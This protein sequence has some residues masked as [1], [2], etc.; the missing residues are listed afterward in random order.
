MP[1][2]AFLSW[3]VIVVAIAV[4][5]LWPEGFVPDTYMLDKLAHFSA[6]AALAI[7]PAVFTTSWRTLLWITAGLIAVGTGMEAA[8]HL[9]PHR[10]ASYSDLAANIAGVLTGSFT[11]WYGRHWFIR[12]ALSEKSETPV[13][14]SSA[15]L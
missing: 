4:F 12:S 10:W 14:P 13:E 1:R 15:R 5:S 7:V 3:I 11:G 6:Y 8:Q 9:L 2:S